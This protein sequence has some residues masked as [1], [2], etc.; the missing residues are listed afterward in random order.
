MKMHWTTQQLEAANR[1][2]LLFPE[3]KSARL[4]RQSGT[5]WKIGDAR[6]AASTQVVLQILSHQQVTLASESIHV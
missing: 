1:K 6:K 4:L 2:Y 5:G 3:S